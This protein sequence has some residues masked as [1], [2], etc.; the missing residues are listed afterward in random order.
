M[1]VC[2]D[3]ARLSG[4]QHRGSL[5]VRLLGTDN[6]NGNRDLSRSVLV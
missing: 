3:E 4:L 1:V 2:C 6:A 5:H